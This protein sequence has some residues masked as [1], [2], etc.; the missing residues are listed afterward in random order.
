MFKHSS[1]VTHSIED[2]SYSLIYILYF[3]CR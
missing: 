3:T 2:A 1:K